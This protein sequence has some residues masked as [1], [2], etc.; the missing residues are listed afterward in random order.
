M[1]K[2]VRN[3]EN[4]IL[5]RIMEIQPATLQQI[6]ETNKKWLTYMIDVFGFEE[7]TF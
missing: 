7:Q 5:Q 1:T 2:T 3:T 6:C 4:L